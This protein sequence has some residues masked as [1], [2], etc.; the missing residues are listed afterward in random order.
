MW[1]GGHPAGLTIRVLEAG[2]LTSAAA[3]RMGL[4]T[5]SPPQLG[6]VP[7]KVPSAHAAQ[8]VH[9]KLQ[10]HA[11]VLSGGK[12]RPQHSQHGRNSST[13]GS[14]D[15]GSDGAPNWVRALRPATRT[16]SARSSR[17]LRLSSPLTRSATRSAQQRR[18]VA[19]DRL[20]AKTLEPRDS[21]SSG[22]GAH[23]GPGGGAPGRTSPRRSRGLQ[24]CE[25]PKATSNSEVRPS[26][27]LRGKI[28][29]ALPL[30]KR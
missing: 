28:R 27:P 19:A 15:S 29:Y 30:R 8:N 9:S 23:R 1:R 11:A 17:S 13:R 12:S 22:D 3:G 26:L 2:F 10:I 25:G 14:F 16:A 20:R 6:H 4:R 7:C 21:G 24:S 5:S 18:S